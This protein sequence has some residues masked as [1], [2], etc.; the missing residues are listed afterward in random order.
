MRDDNYDCI[1][2]A[3]A[4]AIKKLQTTKFSSAKK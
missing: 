4:T 2:I 3:I 1:A